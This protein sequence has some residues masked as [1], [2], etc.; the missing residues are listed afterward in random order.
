MSLCEMCGQGWCGRPCIN[1]PH[2]SNALLFHKNGKPKTL[3]ERGLGW[4]DPPL[5]IKPPPR[6][7]P[8]LVEP[9]LKEFRKRGIKAGSVTEKAVRVTENKPETVTK[10]TPSVT[11]N[12]S[13][14]K[15]GRGRPKSD[16]A[17]SAA[18]RARKSRAKR[19]ADK[20]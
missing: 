19:K 12:K 10:N 17:L 7:K 18:E 13:V 1:D 16:T 8:R 6:S 15:K 11:E 20:S 9:I 14:T 2:K 3:H 4:N 5:Y